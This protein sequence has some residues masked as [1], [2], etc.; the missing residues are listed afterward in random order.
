MNANVPVLIERFEGVL[1]L[2]LNAPHVRNSLQAPGI[3]EGL[4]AGLEQLEQDGDLRAA[5]ITGAGGAFCSGGDLRQLADLGEDEVRARM[6]RNA[7][8]YRR[9]ALSDKLLVAAVDGPAYGAG[10]GLAAAC[11]VVVAGQSAAFCCAFTRVGAMPDAALFWSL[12]ARIGVGQARRLMLW[13]DEIRGLEAL[14][15]GLAD[16]HEPQGSALPLAH[17]LAQRIAQ[18]PARALGRIKAGLRQSPMTLEQALGFQL[19]NAPGLFASDDFREG[20]AA[21]FEKRA[22]RF[23]RNRSDT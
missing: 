8:L 9:I 3:Y 17:R 6:T 4:M 19:D 13:A 15:M 20:A 2:T 21:F 14:A 22:P 23:G 7:W 10:L 5:V 1:Q 18:G 16:E 12:P 11:D